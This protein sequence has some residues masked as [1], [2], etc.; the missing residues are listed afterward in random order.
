MTQE[1]EKLATARHQAFLAGYEHAFDVEEEALAF[2]EANRAYVNARDAQA[3]QQRQKQAPSL[4]K[5]S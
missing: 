4:A 2:R 3:R 1:L 5:A